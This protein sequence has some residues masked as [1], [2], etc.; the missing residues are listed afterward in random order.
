[1]MTKYKVLDMREHED[2][3]RPFCPLFSISFRRMVICESHCA[4]LQT[5]ST[6]VGP[7]NVCAISAMAKTLSDL[8]SKIIR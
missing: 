5:V 7:R 3:S 6:P 2:D 8:N 1:M 4:W